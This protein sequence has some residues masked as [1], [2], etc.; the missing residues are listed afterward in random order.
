MIFHLGFKV[1]MLVQNTSTRIDEMSIIKDMWSKVGV[2]VTLDVKEAGQYAPLVAAGTPYEEMVFRL[3]TSPFLMHLY[4]AY[5]RGPAILNISHINDPPGTDPY[6]EGLFQEQDK[7]LFVDMP[8]V[9][10]LVKKVNR[11]VMEQAYV[12]PWPLSNQYNF[13]WPWLKNYYGVGSGII[14]YSYIDQDLRKSMGY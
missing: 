2:D 13:W 7:L 1:K 5:T 10:E 9:Y 3:Q 8:T 4:Q 11:Y 6:L 14:R 12:I